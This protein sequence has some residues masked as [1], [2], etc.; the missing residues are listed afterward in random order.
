LYVNQQG[1]SGAA[2]TG[3][4]RLIVD[5][6][7]EQ[8]DPSTVRVQLDV[9]AVFAAAGPVTWSLLGP[10]SSSQPYSCPDPYGYLGSAEPDP[11]STTA[12]GQVTIG[13]QV[14]NQAEL[15]GF[16]GHTSPNNASDVLGLY[17]LAPGIVQADSLVPIAE[18]NLCWASDRPMAFDGEFASASLPGIQARSLPGSDLPLDLTRNLYFDNSKENLQP[19]T[20]QYS[21]QA[22][23]LPTSTDPFGWHW[24]AGEGSAAVQ[25]TAT[26]IQV[27]QHEAYLGFVSGVL[28][29]VVGG[30]LVLILQELMEPIRIR[31]RAMREASNDRNRVR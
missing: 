29:G 2:S 5:E 12:G 15:G 6:T 27:A 23:T 25:L 17:G 21:L 26:N 9:F 10:R 28:F 11:V 7:M 24:A 22:G 30:A 8:Q 18:A 20:A 16:T 19:V 4:T 1:A 14:V 13:G 31:R 3:P